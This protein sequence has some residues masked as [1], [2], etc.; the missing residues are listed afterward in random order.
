VIFDPFGD[1][2][3]RGYLRNSQRLKDQAEVK[4]IA[5]RHF[6]KNLGAAFAALS[7]VERI[8]Y[9]DLL[10]THKTL[11]CGIYPWA[12][13]DRM[14]AAPNLAISKGNRRDLFAHP[15]DI[16]RAAEYALRRGQEAAF[17]ASR[18]GEILGTLAYAHPF[19]DGNGR[20]IMVVHTELGTRAGISINWTKADKHDYLIALTQELDR[21]GKG[22]L[23]AYLKPF[24][25]PAVSRAHASAVLGTMR[26]LGPEPLVPRHPGRKG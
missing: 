25:G 12:G 15:Q 17:M 10:A 1:F 21:P 14:T 3:T 9:D 16:R 26:G 6:R 4:A 23:D 11:F 19:L 22:I 13:E 2:E 7:R 5:H 20:A 8:A 18:P 24:I